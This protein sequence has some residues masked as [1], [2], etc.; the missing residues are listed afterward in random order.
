MRYFSRASRGALSFLLLFVALVAGGPS[1]A[2]QES[3]P[4]VETDPALPTV[5]RP[6]TIYFNADQGNK[7]LQGYDGA[8]YAHTGVYTSESPTTWKCVKT[9]WPNNRPDIRMT[10]VAAERYKLEISD[11]RAYYN[12]NNTGCMLGPNEEILSMNFVFRNDDGTLEGKT[13]SGGDI[14]VELADSDPGVNANIETPAV[15]AINP[16]VVDTDTT[17][18]VL[19]IADTIQTDLQSFKLFVDG[20][21]AVRTTNDTIQYSL[22]LTQAG[23]KDV[24]IEARGTDGSVA[25]DS[26]YAVRTAPL[27]DAP[28]PAGLDDGINYTSSTS[29]TLVL[30]APRKSFVHV[31]G[32]F[33]NWEVQPSYQL[34]RERNTAS[35]GQDSTRWWIE[36][37]NLTP[38]KEYRFQ[39]LVDGDIRIP[40][41][42][43]GKVLSTNDQFI[44]AQTYPNLIAYPTGKTQQL[45]SVL[46]TDQAAFNF[47]PFE[48]PPQK[49]LVIYELL[50][51]D[52]IAN[53]NYQTLQDTLAYL[54]R[55]GINAIE[56]M[57]VSE[58]DGNESWGYNPAL[59]FATDKYYGPAKELK[60]FIEMAHQRG[61]A[62]ILDVVYNQQTGQ[63]PFVRLFNDGTYGPPTDDNPWVNRDARHPFNVFYDNNHES[64]FT[65]YWL[66]RANEYW[67]TE[68]NVDGFR[69]DLSKGFTQGPDADGYNDVGAWSSYD[70]ERINT[71]QRMADKIWAVDDNAY[72]I[73]EHF[74]ATDEERA[75]AEYR[76][77]QGQAGMMLW[78]NMNDPYSEAAMGYDE[79]SDL[80]NT[81]YRNRG[82]SVPNY[83]TYMESHDEQWLM[84]RNLAF[85][86]S[87][88]SYDIQELPTALNRQKLVGAFFFTVPGPRMMW[89]FGE[90]G[91]GYGDNGEQCLRPNDCPT[92]APGRTAPKP[93]RWDYR[94]PQ[95]SP[96]RVKLYK[97]W[98]AL[99]NLRNQ[100]EVFTST[101]TQ[102]DL[103]VGAAVDGRRIGL[104]HPSMNAIVVGN[105][106]VEPTDVTANFPTS[107]TWY[108]VFSGKAVSIEAEEQDAA[109]PMAPGEFHVYT[110]EPPAVTPEAGIV[111]Y[112][113]AA[114]APEAP[115]GVEASSN[116]EA[117]AVE[118]SWTASDAVD[119]VAHQ[120]YRGR[121][122]TFDTTGALLATLG[123]NATT[124]T[125]DAVVSGPTYYYRVVALDND[126]MQSASAAAS[127]LL[128]P[129]SIPVSVTRS[130][131]NGAAKDDYRLV[132]LPGDVSRG[133][134][135]TFQGTAGDAW[136]AYW[137]NGNATD[138]LV[139]YTPSATFALRPGRGF[140]AISESAWTVDGDIPTVVPQQTAGS[141]V[142]VTTIPLH[143]GWNIISNP[144]D[145]DV[146]WS[147]VAAANGGSLQ[148][149]WRFNGSFQQA[150]TFVSAR[151]GTAFYFNNQSGLSS[152]TIPYAMQSAA[153]Q[154]SKTASPELLRITATL[155]D[156]RSS[157]V[158][159][160]VAPNASNEVGAEDIIAPSTSFES[161]S[162]RA[163]AP[164]AGARQDRLA[165]SVRA[166][167]QRGG[168]VFPLRLQTP[169]GGRI[170]LTVEGGT[171]IGPAARLVNRT[172]GAVYNL[173]TKQRI[174]LTATTDAVDLALLTGS[175]AFVERQQEKLVPQTVRLWANYP[176]PFHDQTTITY[177]LP[178]AGPVTVEVFDILGRRV[179]VLA[180]GK[181]S[182]GLHR[183]QWNVNESRG[184]IASGLYIVRL[185]ANGTTR[186][187]KVTLVR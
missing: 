179:H 58:F 90:L 158:A 34:N 63:S 59:Y 8:V 26:I 24:R 160:G 140:W 16:V 126:G 76:T 39:Y 163:K 120:V 28:V 75:L 141:D 130:F 41:P 52:F 31:I 146:A 32:D 181:Q 172:T 33:T 82:I 95:Q 61:I 164:G 92:V 49:D 80:S 30:Q 25:A 97:T 174:T 122:A 77:D 89:Q 161:F 3:E 79:G 176:N 175:A 50:V 37:N 67:L 96:N 104:Q 159:L 64:T 186:T 45:V 129:A 148:P 4:V 88:G 147:A 165:R 136:Q 53:H 138:Y 166:R 156:A 27:T 127:A 84:Y 151:S 56:L 180:R 157:T 73:L 115:T 13:A 107:G 10:E 68:F 178:T 135:D 187:R 103:R 1:A 143:E 171:A 7:G 152:L 145:R 118:L 35:T 109:I 105:F 133:L 81:Y 55:M 19:A 18:S 153:A 100:H 78:N 137:D 167:S 182:A 93:I 60:Q 74:A 119:V 6:V 144:F 173:S 128:Y 106:G 132:A 54:D 117:G 184:P 85:G 21:E 71:L 99:I 14:I 91:Y 116:L 87:S 111:P 62:V 94:D 131:G 51:R 2:A 66:D 12:D 162:L 170:T 5:T 168:H 110:S 70:Q 22:S 65:K 108:D 183:V 101:D 72:I 23:R 9:E 154:R 98:S 43:S 124:Y 125:D 46:Q 44:D 86:N 102:V 48:R 155:D 113:V 112:G 15:S 139:K 121:T 11:I 134:G 40:D 20:T 177:T 17:I 114:P 123:P 29:A 57:P 149:I 169:N 42:Y 47:S 83:I 38:G 69:F 142:P 150:E 185:T 36:L